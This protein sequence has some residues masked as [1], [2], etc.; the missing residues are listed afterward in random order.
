[1][2]SLPLERCGLGCTLGDSI[3][4]SPTGTLGTAGQAPD[5]PSHGLH[6]PHALF[7]RQ[8]MALKPDCF[9]L[10]L[11][12]QVEPGDEACQVA[13]VTAYKLFLI[14]VRCCEWSA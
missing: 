7:P 2:G 12:A 14:Q 13:G 5:G 4:S 6:Q 8:V 11:S 10:W 3:E 9:Y 1:M